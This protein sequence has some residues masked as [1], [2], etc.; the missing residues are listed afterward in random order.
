MTPEQV[1]ERLGKAA[2]VKY[3]PIRAA[4]AIDDATNIIQDMASE[5]ERLRAALRPFCEADW[6]AMGNGKFEGKVSN[7]VLNAAKA[8]TNGDRT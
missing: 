7:E 1:L 2:V 4:D 6:Y 3:L 5:I 8:V